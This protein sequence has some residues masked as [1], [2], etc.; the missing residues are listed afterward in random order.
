MIMSIDIKK[1]MIIFNPLLAG[2]DPELEF[3]GLNCVFHVKSFLLLL[4][5]IGSIAV[6]GG[7][8]SPPPGSAPAS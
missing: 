6:L 7:H 1:V 8:G 5:A 2:V 3:G 4:L